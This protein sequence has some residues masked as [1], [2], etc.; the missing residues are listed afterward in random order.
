MNSAERDLLLGVLADPLPVEN[1]RVTSRAVRNWG[2]VLVQ[3]QRHDVVPQLH[4][5]VSVLRE[6]VPKEVR[7]ELQGI[8]AA[9]AL[10]S[11]QLAEE[12]RRITRLLMASGLSIVPWKGPVLA[13]KYYGDVT[14]RTCADLDLLVPPQQAWFALKLL[15][16]DG[17]VLGFPLAEQRWPALRRTVN[18][19]TLRHPRNKWMVEVHWAFFHPMH[20][21]PFDL[22]RYWQELAAGKR[23]G[24]GCLANEETLVLLCAHGTLHLWEKLKWVADIDRVLRSQSSLD[25]ERTFGLAARMGACRC[26]L[27]GLL[28]ARDLCGW[29]PSPDISCRLAEDPVAGRLANDVKMRLF[30][31]QTARRQ[32]LSDHLFLFR[33]R[34]RNR[35]RAKFL[36]RQ[37]FVP[38]QADWQCFA[39]GSYCFPL[40]YL[41]RP[42]R[43]IWKWI[44]R[45]LASRRRPSIW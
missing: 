34:E 23:G 2:E 1:L 35:D 24:E 13:E 7:R 22:S 38:R 15:Q 12:R 26:L 44:F 16:E 28:L 39:P 20:V 4:H 18:H 42:V 45:P 21:L 37:I 31:R 40:F 41:E 33:S 29:L 10:R 17:Y 43:M 3:A 25:W 14:L 27:L 36:L 11:L 5:L 9:G 30:P 6:D 19:L 8:F 32:L